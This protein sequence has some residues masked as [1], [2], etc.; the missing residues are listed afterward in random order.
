MIEIIGTAIALAGF[1]FAVY[2]YSQ[3]QVW[4][5]KEFAAAQLRRLQEDEMLAMC[6][7]MLDYTV[8]KL[9]VPARLKVFTKEESFTHKSELLMQGL[10]PENERSSFEWPLI[11]Y[12]DGFDSLFTYLSEIYD[13]RQSKLYHLEDIEGLRYWLNELKNPRFYPKDTFRKFCEHY[14]YP[15]VFALVEAF[16]IKS[17]D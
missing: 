8:R 1:L 12:R 13:H 16:E 11:A 6:C 2:E 15:K 5:R 3:A 10:Q 4:K 14:Q 7:L 17:T 9:S